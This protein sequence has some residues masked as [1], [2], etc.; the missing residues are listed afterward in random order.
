MRAVAI[1]CVLIVCLNGDLSAD[2]RLQIS[3]QPGYANQWAIVI[4]INYSGRGDDVRGAGVAPLKNAEADA[5]AVSQALVRHFGYRDSG[6]DQTL[7]LLTGEQATKRAIERLFGKEFLK[8]PLRTTA[9]DSVLVFFAGHG[10]REKHENLSQTLI[11]PYDVQAVAGK[12][13]DDTSCISLSFLIEQFRFCPA[14]HKLLI[15][16]SCHSGEVFKFQT[17]TGARFDFDAD[18]FNAQ[19]IQAIAASAGDQFAQD[20]E[21]HSPFTEALLEGLEGKS[22]RNRVFGASA[23]IS[24]IPLRVQQLNQQRGVPTRQT[25]RG[26]PL[27]GD[28]EFFFFRTSEVADTPSEGSDPMLLA[29][30]TLP[31][32]SGRWWF[33]ETPWLVPGLRADR[34]TASSLPQSV[35]ALKPPRDAA[36]K[37]AQASF[38]ENADVALVHKLLR[39]RAEE[40]T[41]TRPREERMALGT[42]LQLTNEELT[43]E[44]TE[45]LVSLFAQHPDPHLR[46]VLHHRLNREDAGDL[47]RSAIDSYEKTATVA[48]SATNGDRS[49]LLRLCWSDYARYL[50]DTGYTLEAQTA[51]RNALA[52]DPDAP[53][54]PLFVM[55]NLLL[56]SR[57]ES[58]AGEWKAAELSLLAARELA[59]AALPNGHPMLATIHDQFG[60]MNMDRWQLTQ[61]RHHFQ[62][63]LEIR[64]AQ[65]DPDLLTRVGTLHNEHGLAMVDRFSGSI[66]EAR[67]RYERLAGQARELLPTAESRNERELVSG[68]VVNSL[69]RLA[70]CYLFATPPEPIPAYETIERALPFCG[71]LSTQQQVRT[72]ARLQ[73]KAAFAL[74]LAGEP[75]EAQHLLAQIKTQEFPQL[76]GK[77]NVELDIFWNLADG[78][79]RTA[80]D[81]TAGRTIL[82]QAIDSATASSKGMAARRQQWEIALAASEVLL[83]SYQP[84]EISQAKLDADRLLQLAAGEFLNPSNLRYLRPYLDAA[85]MVRGEAAE[86]LRIRNLADVVLRAKTGQAA[87]ELPRDRAAVV[88]HLLDQHGYTY[89]VPGRGTDL[90]L[91]PQVIRL[92][93]GRHNLA[94]ASLPAEVTAAVDKMAP[95]VATYWADMGVAPQLTDALFPFP[96]P[97]KWALV[98]A[99]PES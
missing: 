50:L 12:G 59:T 18:L 55:N 57:A 99:A 65:S 81:P 60:W 24:S 2:Q 7:H 90:S 9:Q 3:E 66:G 36:A 51:I 41:N 23:L 13:I 88:F 48:R 76:V 83:R 63:A 11:Y 47:Y 37:P 5:I 87:A 72:R 49:G 95:P 33:E 30:Q 78:I 15:L 82:K 17:R 96:D 54:L 61:A 98:P 73:C 52:S 32:L 29:L 19:V 97:Q 69:E 26:G 22:I 42:L 45:R 16:D 35:T 86:T 21:S 89:L 70:D 4:G 64:Q 75:A 20:G 40:Y 31:G 27:Y 77:Q 25:P 56:K 84:A 38:L 39:T 53:P 67:S 14:K 68:R 94:S 58:T 43:A 44:Q 80:H 74:A 93:F 91:K 1:A 92:P 62:A 34:A 10:D 85:L 46:A 6:P 28:G 8:D 71:S 79:A